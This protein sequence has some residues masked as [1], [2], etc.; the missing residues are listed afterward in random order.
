[1]EGHLKRIPGK[2][3]VCVMEEENKKYVR[4]KTPQLPQL[5]QAPQQ[6]LLKILLHQILLKLPLHQIP[7]K[8]PQ[9]IPLKQI[10]LIRI[11]QQI[12]LIRKRIPQNQPELQALGSHSFQQHQNQYPRQKQR[13]R[14]K[15]VPLAEEKPFRR[16]LYLMWKLRKNQTTLLL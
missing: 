2:I 10:P 5:Q 6:T 8:I 4:Q 7:Q 3:L 9:Q 11:P 16:L 15:L 14:S 12:P 1:M 13:L